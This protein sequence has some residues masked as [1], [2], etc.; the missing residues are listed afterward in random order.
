MALM[1]GCLSTEDGCNLLTEGFL[2]YVTLQ[3]AK[4]MRNHIFPRL[5]SK[6]LCNLTSKLSLYTGAHLPPSADHIALLQFYRFKDQDKLSLGRGH[7]C[8]PERK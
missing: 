5:S 8:S 2:I 3:L 6:R 1:N 4:L 7:C